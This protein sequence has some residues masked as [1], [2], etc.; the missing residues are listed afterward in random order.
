MRLTRSPTQRAV[1]WFY[2]VLF[3][4]G[5]RPLRAAQVCIAYYLL[6]LFLEGY[7][8]AAAKPEFTRIP[9]PTFENLAGL[10]RAPIGAIAQNV[11]A[12]SAP[13]L[14]AFS[15]KPGV[16]IVSGTEDVPCDNTINPVLYA[17]D[18]I[19]PASDFKQVE[20]CELSSASGLIWSILRL[21]MTGL[22]WL[23]CSITLFTWSGSL[24]RRQT[25]SG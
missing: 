14:S 21:L 25:E 5:L 17:A 20:K 9:S 19:L 6:V 4:F 12:V 13:V 2:E 16:L 15:L 23:I 24:I 22:G 18:M 1:L 3:G 10:L 11:Y 7:A 8:N